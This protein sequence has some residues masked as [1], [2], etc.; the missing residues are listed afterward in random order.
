MES[1]GEREEYLLSKGHRKFAIISR[2][3]CGIPM[4]SLSKC[5]ASK[6]GHFSILHTAY[7]RQSIIKT[8]LGA[9]FFLGIIILESRLIGERTGDERHRTALYVSQIQYLHVDSQLFSTSVESFNE[10]GQGVGDDNP[11][12]S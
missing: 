3:T 10:A 9:I 7:R 11:C 6:I 2:A 8:F 12:R 4:V 5:T 1:V